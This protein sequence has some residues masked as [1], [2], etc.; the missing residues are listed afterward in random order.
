MC[1]VA[2]N[3]KHDIH[4]YT[5]KQKCARTQRSKTLTRALMVN[6]QT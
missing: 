3:K 6:S 2:Q 4:K 5:V 1:L